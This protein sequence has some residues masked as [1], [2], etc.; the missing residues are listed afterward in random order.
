MIIGITGPIGSG[1]DT[2]ADYLVSRHGFT[3]LSFAGPLKDA[4]SATFGWDREALEGTTACSRAWR[5]Q[6]DPWWANALNMPHLTPRWVLQNVGTDLFRRHFHIDIWVHSTM[7][8]ATTANGPVVI[9]DTRFINEARGIAG[10]GG[11]VWRVTREQPRWWQHAQQA[12]MGD[13][14]V[15]CILESQDIHE[16]EWRMAE[17]QP[18][19]EIQNTGTLEQLHDLVESFLVSSQ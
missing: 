14:S 19:V 16:S 17:I 2:V 10:Q 5:E 7:R 13:R 3:R 11:K 4:V 12:C 1:K 8:R 18:D 15:R 9:S 6:V